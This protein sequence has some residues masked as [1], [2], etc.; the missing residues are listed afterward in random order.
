MSVAEER[1][2]GDPVRS[3]KGRVVK[4]PRQWGVGLPDDIDSKK[5]TIPKEKQLILMQPDWNNLFDNCLLGTEAEA[6]RREKHGRLM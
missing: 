3:L 2:K 5:T 1:Y 4:T 6:T